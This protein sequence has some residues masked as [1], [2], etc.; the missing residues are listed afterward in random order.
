MAGRVLSEAG[1]VAEQESKMPGTAGALTAAMTCVD[2]FKTKLTSR[3]YL[4]IIKHLQYIHRARRVFVRVNYI[5]ILAVHDP[6]PEHAKLLFSE[7]S[8]LCEV[9]RGGERRTDIRMGKVSGDCLR[10]LKRSLSLNCY[11]ARAGHDNLLIVTRIVD[12]SS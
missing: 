11:G 2:E 1:R 12:V 5:D 4:D 9:V 10:R 6:E 7:R 8:T 3:E